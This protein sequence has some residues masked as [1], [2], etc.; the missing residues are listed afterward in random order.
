M[1]SFE[2]VFGKYSFRKRNDLPDADIA[3]IES[4]FNIKFPSDYKYYQLLLDSEISMAKAL[5]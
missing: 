2:D 4:M 5:Y 3:S 1:I